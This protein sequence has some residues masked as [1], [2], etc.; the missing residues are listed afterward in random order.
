MEAERVPNSRLTK[1][2][3]ES[4]K[5]RYTKVVS[6]EPSTMPKQNANAKRKMIKSQKGYLTILIVITSIA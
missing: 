2:S 6:R 4:S 3:G 1:Y 5:N